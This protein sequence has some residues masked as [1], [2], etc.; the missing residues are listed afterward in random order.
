MFGCVEIIEALSG[1][2]RVT[3]LGGRTEGWLGVLGG[4]DIDLGF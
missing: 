1:V 3:A 4:G 2:V